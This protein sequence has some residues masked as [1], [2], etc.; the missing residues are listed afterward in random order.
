MTEKTRI[1]ESPKEQAE[2]TEIHETLPK[3]EVDHDSLEEQQG[4]LLE[5]SRETAEQQATPSRLLAIEKDKP[6]Q[7]DDMDFATLK[8]LK[9]D[10]YHSLLARAREQ[11]PMLSK[12]FSK[13]IH[14]KHIETISN[15]GSQTVARPSGLLGG[16][17]GALAGS[18]TLLY[19]SKYYGF[20]YNYAFFFITF[21]AGF[22]V[23]LVVELLLK[24]LKRRS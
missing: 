2:V 1:H 13:I 15:I 23:G 18:I 19:Y 8:A 16:G 21:L 14:E 10:S 7:S 6:R 24:L 11:L 3:A 12:Q 17:L 9:S 20:R 4:T 5:T 22:L